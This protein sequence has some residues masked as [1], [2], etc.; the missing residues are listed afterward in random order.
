MKLIYNMNILFVFHYK[1]R[2]GDLS[3]ILRGLKVFKGNY[4]RG[5]V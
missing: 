2:D 5:L 4:E 1:L 3:L